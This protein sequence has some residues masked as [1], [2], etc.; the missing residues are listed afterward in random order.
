MS[1]ARIVY[2]VFLVL[3]ALVSALGFTLYRS[4]VAQ[5]VSGFPN[6]GQFLDYS[7][8]PLSFL[9]A[10]ILTVCYVT[11]INHSFKV[12]AVPIQLLALLWFLFTITGGI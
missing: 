11:K 2:V 1:A 9:L 4:V 6:A 3:W 10:N 5:Q 7:L 12:A 8:V